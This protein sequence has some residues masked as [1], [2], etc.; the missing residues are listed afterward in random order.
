MQQYRIAIIGKSKDESKISSLS[1]QNVSYF[2]S[3]KDC[4]KLH[5]DFDFEIIESSDTNFIIQQLSHIRNSNNFFLLP[6]FCT[7][8]CSNICDGTYIDLHICES[9]ISQFKT[10]LSKIIDIN[11]IT[12]DWQ[13]KCLTYLYTRDFSKKLEAQKDWQNQFLYYYPIVNIF[14]QDQESKYILEWIKSLEYT[15]MLIKNKLVDSFFC[16]NNCTSAYLSFS[17][18][19]PECGSIDINITDFLHCFSC[20]NI[21]PEHLF[22]GDDELKCPQC[23]SKL[24]HIGI[25]Y[26]R[27]LESYICNSCKS[28]SIETDAKATCMICDSSHKTEELVKHQIHDYQLSKKAS[29]Y[30]ESNI[31]YALNVFNNINYMNPEFFY[32]M[33]EWASNMQYR[34]DAYVF[35]LL[36]VKIADDFNNDRINNLAKSLKDILRTTDILTRVKER[37]IF[38]YLPNTPADGA[39]IVQEKLILKYLDYAGGSKTPDFKIYFSKD[40]ERI[41]SAKELIAKIINHGV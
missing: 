28:H 37:N 26:D 30:I 19:C 10:K 12:L 14:A 8:E 4:D 15:D 40:L 41:E 2:I 35:S 33:L 1:Q 11:K 27:P 31:D 18:H 34:E 22:F 23:H 7:T 25:D 3:A 36:T 9:F 16:C 21:E 17:E 24:R 13:T 38:I 5:Q 29:H 39:K 6:I 20:G 32:S